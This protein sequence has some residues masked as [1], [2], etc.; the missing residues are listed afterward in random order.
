MGDETA[1]H[2][3]VWRMSRMGVDSFMISIHKSYEDY[4]EFLRS[5]R[6]ELGESVEDV[7]S[8]LVRELT[9]SVGW[10]G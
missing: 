2:H 5:H 9:T 10:W 6:L 8:I 1:I 4:D 3:Y 7:Q